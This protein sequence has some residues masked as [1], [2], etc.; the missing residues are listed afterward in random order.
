MCVNNLP[1]VITWERNKRELNKRPL[2]LQANAL[3]ITPS[4]HTN[5]V[6]L[7][8]ALPYSR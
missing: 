7:I 8:N 1:K 3:T 2:E 5:G 6:W 4:G